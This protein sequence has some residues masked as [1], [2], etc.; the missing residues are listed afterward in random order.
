MSHSASPD[1]TTGRTVDS[2]ARKALVAE[3]PPVLRRVYTAVLEHTLAS[4]APADPA[5]LV[6]V[7]SAL[8]ELSEDPLDFRAEAVQELLWFGISQFCADLR[9]V[10][11]TRCTEALFATVALT[12]ADDRFATGG[13]PLPEVFAA[14]RELTQVG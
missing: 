5:A 3:L 2:A 7:L 12:I 9:L 14:M 1:S 8:D 13:D 6:I 11:P 4:G 10:A